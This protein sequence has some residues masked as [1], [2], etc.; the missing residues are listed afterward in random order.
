MCFADLA[1][2]SN[3]HLSIWIRFVDLPNWAFR[4][5][6]LPAKTITSSLQRSLDWLWFG[7]T[8]GPTVIS[9][10]TGAMTFHVLGSFTSIDLQR[11]SNQSTTKNKKQPTTNFGKF[12][13]QGSEHIHSASWHLRRSGWLDAVTHHGDT[14]LDKLCQTVQT[15]GMMRWF[16]MIHDILIY[17]DIP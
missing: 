12:G 7:F 9:Y 15:K 14:Q 16:N 1:W 4:E 5:A 10:C 2:Y 11:R 3:F 6:E 8:T 17:Y 13:T